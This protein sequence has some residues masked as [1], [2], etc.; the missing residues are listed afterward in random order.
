MLFFVVKMI[1][2]PQWKKK[3]IM[4]QNDSDALF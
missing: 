1:S 4:A 2:D 3:Q